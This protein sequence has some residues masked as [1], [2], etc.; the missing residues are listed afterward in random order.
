MNT[1]EYLTQLIDCKA[2]MKAAIEER[3]VTVSGGLSTYA[4]AIKK[5]DKKHIYNNYPI[6]KEETEDCIAYNFEYN[7]IRI[8]KETGVWTLWTGS[9]AASNILLGKLCYWGYPKWKIKGDKNPSN[10]IE[11]DRHVFYDLI[12][13]QYIPTLD[14]SELKSV[15]NLFAGL[16]TL[17]SFAGFDTSNYDSLNSLCSGCLELRKIPYIETTHITS[18]VETFALCESLIEI[19]NLSFANA[20]ICEGTFS[21]CKKLKKIN[22]DFSNNKITDARRMFEGCESLNK[23]ENFNVTNLVDASSMFA[24]CKS[25]T[26]PPNFIGQFNNGNASSMFQFCHGFTSIKRLNTT[27]ITNMNH[28]FHK[29]INL[30]EISQLDTSKVSD[31]RGMFNGCK[32]LKTL[33]LLDAGRVEYINNDTFYNCVELE[34][35]G[36]LKD[37]GKIAGGTGSMNLYLRS[38]LKLTKQSLIN[39]INN[40]YDRLS[41]GMSVK[42]VFLTTESLALLSD[43]EI[44]I[45]TNKGWIIND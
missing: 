10:G 19:P 42:S 28:M 21:G 6:G 3:G 29:C 26:D 35:F 22:Y 31:M 41:N 15:V 37:F 25:L 44:A 34:N 36:G 5:I 8:N 17:K 23:I 14:I 32:L 9:N 13:I 18:F 38:C 11:D 40:L 45:A 7:S 12:N 24:G 27:G 43:E 39:I 33:P 1:A 30:T 4:D 20:N 16:R 2:D